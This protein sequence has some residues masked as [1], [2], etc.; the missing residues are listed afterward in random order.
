MVTV[1]MS[2]GTVLENCTRGIP[3]VNPKHRG[4]AQFKVVFESPVQ[5]SFSTLKAGNQGLVD[6]LAPSVLSKPGSDRYGSTVVD[7]VAVQPQFELAHCP[8]FILFILFY[9]N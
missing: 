2:R 6:C 9:N 3:V 4:P 1:L 8:Y 5:P 7:P